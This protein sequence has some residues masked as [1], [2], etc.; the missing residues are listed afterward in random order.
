M[1]A[2]QEGVARRTEPGLGRVPVA[3]GSDDH[4]PGVTGR[5]QQGVC[6]VGADREGVDVDSGVFL[7]RSGHVEARHAVRR[8]A[9]DSGAVCRAGRRVRVAVAL[10]AEQHFA[11]VRV[12]GRRRLTEPNM[13]R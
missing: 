13:P 9:G 2:V 4:E 1:E 3:V 7:A 6:R 11:S 8:E 10:Q 5:L 12:G